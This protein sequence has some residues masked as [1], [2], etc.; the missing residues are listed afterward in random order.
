MNDL[1]GIWTLRDAQGSYDVAMAIPGDGVSALLAA[2]KIADPYVGRNEYDTRWIADRDWTATRQFDFDGSGKQELEISGL[3]CVA[4][5]SLNGTLILTA[6]NAFRT[7][8]VDVTDHLTSGENEISIKFKSNTVEAKRRQAAQPYYVPYSVDNCP[9]PDG[10]MLR[11]VQ[12]DF[13]WDWNIALAPFGVLGKI[14]IHP[15]AVRIDA[16]MVH[17]THREGAVDLDITVDL[18]GQPDGH[19]FTLEVAG[20]EI[21]GSVSGESINANVSIADPQLWWPA[22]QGDQHLYDLTVSVGDQTE[23]RKIGLRTL[24]LISEPDEIGRSFLFTVNGRKIFAKGANWIPQDALG[25]NVTPEATRDL[26]QSAVDANMNMIRIWGGGRY[27]ADWFYDLCSELGLMV[28]QDFMFACN[29]YPAD[30]AFLADVDLEAREQ[31]KRLQHHAC[32]ALWCGD[33][34]LIGALTWFPETRANRDTYLVGYDRLNRTIETAL[35]QTDPRAN[36]WPSSPSPGPMS[37][38]DAWH[39]DSSGDMHFWSVWHENKNFEH[40]R[41]VNPRFCSEFG[42]QSFPSN[43]IVKSFADAEDM[44]LSSPVMESH[45]KNKGG[46]ERIGATMFRYFR[47]P[48]GFENFVYLSQVQQGLAIKTAVDYWRSIKPICMGA[49]YWQLND[50]WPV[51]S[52]A[53]L[54]HGGD[55]KLLHHMAKRF[56]APISVSVYEKDG[57][58]RFVGVNDTSEPVEIELLRTLIDMDGKMTDLPPLKGIVGTDA[59]VTLGTLNPAE[60]PADHI[61]GYYWRA[62]DGASGGNHFTPVPYKNLLLKNPQISADITTDGNQVKIKLSTQT[63]AL[64]VALE[65]DVPGKFSSNAFMMVPEW[66]EE[67]TFTPA[68]GNA[69]AA[70]KTIT[71]RDLWSSSHR[72]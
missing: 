6:D 45:Q 28:W 55:W 18:R 40:Y 60:I 10:N 3:D 4:E 30:N 69:E 33:N 24:E 44:N 56:F 2:G 50:T 23:T 9:I 1:A 66:G 12:C 42:F 68:D 35:K 64:F 11:K 41:D 65:A 59:A 20:Q 62:S 19:P 8:H 63:L 25:S 72:V 58:V 7:Y 32:L 52:W 57:E 16:I 31:V 71:I 36:W 29:I 27:E 17:Q 5:V 70:A 14:V 61:L 13:G 54:D 51:A 47:F 21:R 67:V 22:G 48:E 34:E 43:R 26:L 46:N 37:F 53:S 15:A 39:D 49:L 38:G